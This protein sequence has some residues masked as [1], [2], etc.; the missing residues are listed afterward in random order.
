MTTATNSLA[1]V[2]GNRMA[3][4]LA[5]G[6]TVTWRN[7][8]SYVRIPEALFFSSIQPMPLSA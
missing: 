3:M 4:A 2:G 7:L 6:W 5:D 8:I 1:P